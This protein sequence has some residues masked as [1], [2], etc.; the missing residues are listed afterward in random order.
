MAEQV[1]GSA[2]PLPAKRF[3]MLIPAMAQ[4]EP[5]PVPRKMPLGYC[6]AS[7]APSG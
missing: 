6:L 2:R 3:L 7:A 1:K 4:P 5:D